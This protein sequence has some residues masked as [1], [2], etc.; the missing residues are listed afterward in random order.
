MASVLKLFFG[1]GVEAGVGLHAGLDTLAAE[2]EAGG[3]GIVGGVGVI[4]FDPLA[5]DFFGAAAEGAGVGRA[6]VF[7]DELVGEF[8]MFFEFAPAFGGEDFVGEM[9][10]LQPFVDGFDFGLGTE[11]NPGSELVVE[12][13]THVLE[14][15]LDERV[16]PGGD[17]DGLARRHAV[18]IT[19]EAGDCKREENKHV[20]RLRGLTQR[21]RGEETRS[22]EVTKTHEEIVLDRR[23]R[24]V[25]EVFCHRA[26][27]TQ[28][29]SQRR[30]GREREKLENGKW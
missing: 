25:R 11:A 16:G 27:A 2:R 21:I 9:V 15:L 3:A 26:T 24:R 8:G 22:Y 4:A 23:G 29:C 17:F 30:G 14:A 18:G 10:A 1:G 19:V 20:R 6:A 28:R 13:K 7:Q 5:A 12:E